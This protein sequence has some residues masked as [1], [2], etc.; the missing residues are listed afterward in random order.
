MTLSQNH[1]YDADAPLLNVLK[2]SEVKKRVAS[3]HVQADND[4]HDKEELAMNHRMV[5]AVN[6]NLN[7]DADVNNLAGGAIHF[8]Q[9]VSSMP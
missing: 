8:G 5:T 6:T 1:Y 4:A 9:E 2:P 3:I 7:N